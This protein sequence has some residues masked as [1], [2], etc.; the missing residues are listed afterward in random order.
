MNEQIGPGLR[1]LISSL[2]IQTE[3]ENLP[4]SGQEAKMDIE[5]PNQTT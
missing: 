1:T 5:P 4:E 2:F 3:E